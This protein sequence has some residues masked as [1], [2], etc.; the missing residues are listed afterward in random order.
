MPKTYGTRV[1]GSSASAD[2]TAPTLHSTDIAASA[3]TIHNPS[4]VGQTG[5]VPMSDGAKWVAI[6]PAA[7][8]SEH[9]HAGDIYDADGGRF[10]VTNLLSTGAL[11]NQVVAAD[12]SDGLV[13]KTLD[14]DVIVVTDD[15]VVQDYEEVIVCNKATAMT[16][17]LPEATA[18][19]SIFYVKNINTGTVTVACYGLYDTIDGASTQ[20]IYQWESVTLCDYAIG[21][22][23]VL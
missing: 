11:K 8:L 22:W 15:H 7:T 5:K 3:P 16:I 23:V 17:T 20:D 6:D 19:G 9:D 13:I 14:H 2:A 12:G 21:G 4:P 1:V 18:S 10:L